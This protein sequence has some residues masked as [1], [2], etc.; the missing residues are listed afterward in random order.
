[1]N[2]TSTYTVSRQSRFGVVVL[3]NAAGEYAAPAVS[4]DTICAGI[5]TILSGGEPRLTER[6]GLTTGTLISF[7]TFVLAVLIVALRTAFLRRFRL[8]ADAGGK[9]LRRAVAS[10]V[11]IDFQLPVALNLT[12]WLMMDASLFYALAA[13]PEQAIPLAILCL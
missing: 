13:I 1:M 5:Q 3:A 4:P 6:D 12:L 2:Y 11:I 10:M 9:R 8:A 7:G